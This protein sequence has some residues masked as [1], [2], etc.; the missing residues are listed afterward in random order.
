MFFSIVSAT[1]RLSLAFYQTMHVFFCSVFLEWTSQFGEEMK[2]LEEAQSQ[3][4]WEKIKHY[5]FKFI[6]F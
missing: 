2:Q 5:L 1:L 6:T 4:L 3:V